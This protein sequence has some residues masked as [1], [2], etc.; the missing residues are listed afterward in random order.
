MSLAATLRA[1]LLGASPSLACSCLLTSSFDDLSGGTREE[2]R[3]CGTTVATPPNFCRM[4]KAQNVDPVIDGRADEFCGRIEPAYFRV[5]DGALV[6][7]APADSSPVAWIRFAW[8]A[9]GLHFH[10]AVDQPTVEISPTDSL[11]WKGDSVEIFAAAGD[12]TRLTGPYASATGDKGVVHVIYSP[13]NN[14]VRAR[15]TILPSSLDQPT[16][17]ARRVTGGYEVEGLLPWKILTPLGTS[18]VLS[19]VQINVAVNYVVRG[20]RYQ[21]AVFFESRDPPVAGCAD[22][23]PT[24]DDRTWCRAVLG[25]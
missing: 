1:L 14:G 8:H 16:Y 9:R 5:A 10:I 12:P 3:S 18:E 20:V 24:C 19:P 7:D 2:S 21:N 13:P 6:K 22:S 4:V 23:H 15:A 11:L 25:T 17:A